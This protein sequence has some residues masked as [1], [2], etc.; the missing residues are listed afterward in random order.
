MKNKGIHF[1]LLKRFLCCTNPAKMF[2]MPAI[3]IY[4]AHN[5]EM[6]IVV[7]ILTIMSRVIACIAEL[8]IT[9]RPDV[10]DC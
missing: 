4:P 1:L 8:S 10:S 9:S 2:K 3:E 7:G 5:V 6:L